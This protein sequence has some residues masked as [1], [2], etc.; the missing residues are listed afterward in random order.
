MEASFSHIKSHTFMCCGP[1]NSEK[2][3]IDYSTLILILLML[4]AFHGG[5]NWIITGLHVVTIP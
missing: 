2:H 1:Y 3:D 4:S 5:I